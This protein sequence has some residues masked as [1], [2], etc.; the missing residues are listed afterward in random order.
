MVRNQL[1]NIAGM[2]RIDRNSA[3]TIIY[4]YEIKQIVSKNVFFAATNAATVDG[5]AHCFFFLLSLATAFVFT[6]EK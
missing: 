5:I 4:E 2:T 3:N 1:Q 6:F